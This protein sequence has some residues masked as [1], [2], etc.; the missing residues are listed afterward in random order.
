MTEL[1]QQRGAKRFR[2]FPKGHVKKEYVV[3]PGRILD[4]SAEMK[5]LLSLSL[6]YARG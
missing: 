5:R 6:V 2:Y 3:L 4:D 1:L